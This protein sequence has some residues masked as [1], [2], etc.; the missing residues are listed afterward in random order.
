MIDSGGTKRTSIMADTKQATGYEGIEILVKIGMGKR[1][2]LAIRTP[3]VNWAPKLA[4][5]VNSR[6]VAGADTRHN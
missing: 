6:V 2:R 5:L 4:L 3:P 1:L